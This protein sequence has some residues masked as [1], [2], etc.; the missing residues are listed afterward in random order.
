M[1]RVPLADPLLAGSKKTPM[2]QLDPAARLPPQALSTTK[3][4]ELAVTLVM[5]REAL[6]EF[7]AVTVSDRPDLGDDC[8]DTSLNMM[9]CRLSVTAVT[10][11][12]EYPCYGHAILYTRTAQR[13]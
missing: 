5:V 3:S 12:Y 1:A 13:K 6:P 4:L 11:E 9:Q 10:N 2:A 7:V 8:D